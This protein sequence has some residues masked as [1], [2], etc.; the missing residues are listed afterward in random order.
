MTH[1]RFC[2]NIDHQ[3]CHEA[4]VIASRPSVNKHITLMCGEVPSSTGYIKPTGWDPNVFVELN[5]SQLLSKINAMKEYEGEIRK[6]PHPR[7]PE[8][9]KAIAKFRGSESG[10]Y[11]A[12]SF[13]L[14]T[15]FS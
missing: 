7:S 8:V 11:Y 6:D 1:H 13:M 2:S 4:A 5:E 9:L 3:Y 12:E 14:H 10:F 15:S